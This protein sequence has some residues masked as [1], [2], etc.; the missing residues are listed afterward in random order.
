MA[1]IKKAV[2]V[3]AINALEYYQDGEKI[4]FS[5]IGGQRQL[6]Y[7]ATQD[8]FPTR[9]SLYSATQYYTTSG[10]S[11]TKEMLNG[12]DFFIVISDED[13]GGI[14]SLF[15]WDV[16]TQEIQ[17]SYNFPNTMDA[18]N[19]SYTTQIP[20][21][22]NPIN[23]STVRAALDEITNRDNR[24]LN[25]SGDNMTGNITF[26]T[27]SSPR[28]DQ[29][30]GSNGNIL[31]ESTPDRNHYGDIGKPTTIYSAIPVQVTNGLNAAGNI[32]VNGQGVYSPSN[33]PTPKDIGAVNELT[34]AFTEDPNTTHKA[35][36]LTSH[37]NCP[38]GGSGGRYYFIRT[39]FFSD[40]GAAKQQIAYAYAAN[41][42][43]NRVYVRNIQTGGTW[44]EWT[45]L[46]STNNPPPEPE[47]LQIYRHNLELQS[48]EGSIYFQVLAQNSPYARLSWTIQRFHEYIISN[49][50]GICHI[51]ASLPNG[52]LIIGIETS[53]DSGLIMRTPSGSSFN[54]TFLGDFV[55][56]V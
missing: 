1:T 44:S 5:S 13:Q 46:Y 14:Q 42:L 36:L 3:D 38:T 56:D 12:G 16:E 55:S 9:L 18:D 47:F 28:A 48:S 43:G 45:E 2:N 10:V 4:D 41:G 30:R 23:S 53:S 20:P 50:G 37:T 22:S 39:Y 31:I 24:K 29:Y 49:M 26:A 32:T 19:I 33:K 34:S 40:Y 25:K 7:T 8:N 15:S 27:G 11:I 51:T 17:H 35:M 54:V 52:I 21:A 6:Y